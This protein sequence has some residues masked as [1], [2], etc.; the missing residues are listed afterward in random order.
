MLS[1]RRALFWV[2]LM[3]VAVGCAGVEPEPTARSRSAL[4]A[5]PGDPGGTGDPGPGDPPPPPPPSDPPLDP[6]ILHGHPCN[7]PS[8][9]FLSYG[10]HL[11][12][13][14]TLIAPDLVLTAAHCLAAI[15]GRPAPDPTG[16]YVGRGDAACPTTAI[17][18]ASAETDPGY[19]PEPNPDARTWAAHDAGLLRL[20]GPL[21]GG[22]P[23]TVGTLPASGARLDL[24]GFGLDSFQPP[25]SNEQRCATTTGQLVDGDILLGV[26][27]V[28]YGDSGGPAYIHGTNTVVGVLARAGDVM[29]GDRPLAGPIDRA[30]LDGAI[31]RARQRFTVCQNG[32]TSPCRPDGTTCPPVDGLGQVM[33]TCHMG[34]RSC[35]NGAWSACT[36]FVGP[37]AEVCGNGLDDD[38]DGTPDDGCAPACTCG[39]GVCSCSEAQTCPS[40]CASG[41][42]VPVCPPNTTWNPYLGSCLCSLSCPAGT[43]LDP[44]LCLCQTGCGDGFCSFD[45]SWHTCPLDCT[46]PGDSCICGVPVDRNGCPPGTPG[47]P[48]PPVC[49]DGNCDVAAGEDPVSCP[50]DCT[51]GGPDTP[52]GGGSGGGGGGGDPCSDQGFWDYVFANFSYDEAMGMWNDWCGAALS[53]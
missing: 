53:E 18:G 29:C 43:Q 13:T 20:S 24:T 9:V 39:D 5:D 25:Q 34:T 48:P 28:C 31:E 22:V 17:S 3:V 1:T 36:G 26:A 47:C 38:C 19:I 40:D 27:G 46:P 52:P 21:P 44:I 23:A 11:R 51:P 8:A 35:A 12:C 50:R 4:R 6:A 42:P 7:M 33:G 15:S 41:P 37:T 49:G 10:S 2:C 32:T 16:I 14:G 30:W 45:E